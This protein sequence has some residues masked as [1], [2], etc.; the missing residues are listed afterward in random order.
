[1]AEAFAPFGYVWIQIGVEHVRVPAGDRR[2]SQVADDDSNIE[3]LMPKLRHSYYYTKPTI[4]ELAAK[5]RV[6]PGYCRRGIR[7]FV[8]GRDG[9]GSIRFLRPL[10]LRRLDFESFFMFD[11]DGRFM[12]HFEKHSFIFG[13]WMTAEITLLVK[14]EID[15]VQTLITKTTSDSENGLKFA[16]YD[17]I[18]GEVKFWVRYDSTLGKIRFFKPNSTSRMVRLLCCLP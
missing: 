18:N 14:E 1:M 9:V 8:V 6:E 2:S 17:P 7:N 15:D 16:S 13:F 12:C 10:D 4:E 5:E 11:D 3:A